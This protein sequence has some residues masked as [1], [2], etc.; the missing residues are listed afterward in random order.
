MF[1]SIFV[2]SCVLVSCVV[3]MFCLEM[4]VRESP[5]SG[6]LITATQ[7]LFVASE[8]F[9]TV[10]HFGTASRSIP[11][12]CY[13]I[14]VCLFFIVQVLNNYALAFNISAPLHMIFRSGSLIASLA[15]NVILMKRHY[16]WSRHISVWM[17]TIGVIVCTYASSPQ[18]KVKDDEVSPSFITWTI[19]IAMLTASLFLSARMGLFQEEIYRKYGKHPMEALYYNHMLPLPFFALMYS[20][21]MTQID[22]FNRSEPMTVLEITMPRLWWLLVLNTISQYFCIR[23]VFKLTA[24]FRSLTVTLVVTLRKFISLVVSIVYFANPFTNLHWLGTTLVFLGTFLYAD[25][26]SL[27]FRSQPKN[28]SE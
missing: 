10:H 15:L 16:P 24:E 17:V 25:I 20:D 13:A 26:F 1:Y 8:G 18:S 3:N 6:N 22:E 21:I 28:K 19:G 9:I 14:L 11:L 5:N 27:P 7:F 2:I 23:S 4:I 12:K